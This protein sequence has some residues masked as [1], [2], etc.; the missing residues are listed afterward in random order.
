MC[1]RIPERV[2]HARGVGAHGYFET[3][4]DWSDLT[5]AQFLRQPGKKTPVFVR[6]STV[7]GSRGSPDTVRDVRGFA[8]RFY[9]D[10]GNFDLVGNVIAPFFVHDAIKFP[11][12]IHAGKPHPDREIPQAGTAHDTAY[13]FFGKFPETIH[14][15]LWALSGRGLVR[16]FRQ[17][18]GFGVHTFRLINEEGKS[19]FVK[20]IW[21]PLQGLSN[22]LWDE[23]QKIAGKN[24]DFHRVDLYTAIDKGDYPE[25]ELGVQIIPEEDEHKFD[26]DLLDPTKIVPES[27]VPFT[28]LGK[29]VL[30]RN[31][32]N[33]FAETEQVTFCIGNVVRGI[34]FTNDSLLQG[35]LFSYMDTQLNRMNSANYMQLPINRPLNAV[36]N[37]QRDGYMQSTIHKGCVAYYP[38]QLQN[39]TPSQPKK[40]YIDY[41]EQINNVRKVK[42]HVASVDDHYTHAQLFYNSLT[43]AE[44]QQ[45]VEGLRFEVGKSLDL[46]VRKTMIDVLNRVDNQL[47]RRVAFAVNVPLPDKVVDNPGHKS[48]GLSI[49]ERPHPPHIKT[50]MVAV[51]VAE[52]TNVEDAKAIYEF[53]KKEGAYVEY[54]GPRLGNVNGLEVTNTFLT[55][56]SVLHDA[57]FVPDGEKAIESFMDTRTSFPY[58]EPAVF[59]LDAFRHGKPIGVSGAGAKLLQAAK[60]PEGMGESE[61]VLIGKTAS[62]LTE[63]FKKALIKQRFW[64]RLP[65]DPEI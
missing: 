37:N 65:I 20:F 24:S 54:V 51:L 35:R 61:G 48:V 21:K 8:T 57:V 46:N 23:A 40:P 10:E 12:V 7:L 60:V 16:S 11:D 26:F 44:Q 52:G 25:Y 36:N 62:E 29:M 28:P 58:E 31:V 27:Q 3:Y 47:A 17:V 49:E 45:T 50:K 6:F 64:S 19:V 38:N 63:G 30:N 15:V 33:F 2:V 32:E 34:G 53:L 59:V 14:T 56:N 4:K 9:T 18:D 39:N 55:T 41:P 5:A 13:D 22:L 42:A 43:P 1:I